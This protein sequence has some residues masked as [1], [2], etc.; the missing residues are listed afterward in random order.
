MTIVSHAHPFVIGVDTHARTHTLAIM[1]AL[2]GEQLGSEQFPATPAGMDRAI[3]WAGRCTGGDLATL[4][5]I[6][7]IGS[8]G[9]KLAHTVA[10]IG[11]LVVEA[12]QMNARSRRGVA[13]SDPLD[14]LAIASAARSTDV[15]AL[16][17]P[18]LE[19]GIRAALRILVAARGQMT[20]ERAGNINA[21]IA[22]VRT[23][24]LG[25]DARRPLSSVQVKEIFRWRAR[26]EE[27]AVAIARA[28]AIRLAT[29][30]VAL[31][32]EVECNQ[33]RMTEL[34]QDSTAAPLLEETR[35]GPVI[36]ATIF[37]TWSHPGRVRHEAAFASLAGVNPIP[38]SSGN[39]VR[40]RLNR[41][42][43][44]RLNK[45]PHQATIVSMTHDPDTR[46]YVERRQGE[47]RTNREIRRC[48]QRY[49]AR[50]LYRTLNT[51]YAN[52]A[53]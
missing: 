39:T 12:P 19:K 25:I 46:A 47:G 53:P 18:R 11:Y 9:A 7:G 22:V 42:G 17:R 28:E 14:A 37:T 20:T 31:T 40:H 30:V 41:I 38:A 15:T 34:L 33:A 21:L 3:G 49:L 35:I 29:R 24:D 16:R 45:A 4:W 1:V 32:Q 6:E 26:V 36:A 48:L 44:R 50:H 27:W 5:V 2:T 52:P 10:E 13:K 43:D 8:Y 23:V 51:L